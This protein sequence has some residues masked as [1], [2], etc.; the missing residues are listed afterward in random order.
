MALACTG[1]DF[2]KA[3]KDNMGALG[4][5]VPASLTQAPA[6]VAARVGAWV[7]AYEKFGK[8]VT[9]ADVIGAG[10]ASERLLVFGAVYASFW[11]G[12]AVGSLMVATTKYL[13]CGTSPTATANAARQFTFDTGFRIPPTIL[14]IMQTNPMIFAVGQAG[15][16]AYARRAMIPNA[17]QS[18]AA[19]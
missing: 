6:N 13:D 15:R 5:D 19:K 17:L 16:A 12:A 8:A 9:L 4:L 1:A 18:V 2:Y 7:A 3:F 10:T 11:L 14:A